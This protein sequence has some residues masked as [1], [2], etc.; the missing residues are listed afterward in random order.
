MKQNALDLSGFPELVE[1]LRKLPMEFVADGAAIVHAHAI[2]AGRQIEASYPVGPT[3][4]LKRGVRVEVET[5]AVHATARVRSTAHHSWLFEHG[6]KPRYWNG[7]TTKRKRPW[8]G[9]RKFTGSMSAHKDTA[10]FIT[11]AMRRREL[12]KAA[13]IE[14]VERAGLTVTGR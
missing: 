4:N 3:G 9:A 6:S 11:I 10:S 1:A 12:M 14:L 13:L 2:E 8:S 5:S 7:S